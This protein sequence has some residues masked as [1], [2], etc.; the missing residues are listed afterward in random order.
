MQQDS[1]SDQASPL[2]HAVRCT[3]FA[4]RGIWPALGLVLYQRRT[5][6]IVCPNLYALI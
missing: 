1:G 3:A 6:V 4:E 2:R 5:R